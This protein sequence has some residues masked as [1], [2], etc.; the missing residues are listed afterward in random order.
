ML[1]WNR[2]RNEEISVEEIA[3]GEQ[4]GI[5]V[6]KSNPELTKAINDALAEMK[7]DGTLQ[8]IWDKWMV[9]TNVPEE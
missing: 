8:K 6:S 3:T 4:Y 1:Y 9:E 2:K 7:S 5:A